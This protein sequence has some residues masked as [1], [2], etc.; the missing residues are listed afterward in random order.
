MFLRIQQ[1]TPAHSAHKIR[2][3]APN[4]HERDKPIIRS[5]Q[6]FKERCPVESAQGE[7]KQDGGK[8]ERGPENEAIARFLRFRRI[9]KKVPK[10]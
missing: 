10:N 4:Q 8:Q 3:A 9:G 6:R 2:G 7:I 5:P 1:Y